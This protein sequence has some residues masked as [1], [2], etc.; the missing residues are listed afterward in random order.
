MEQAKTAIYFGPH[1]TKLHSGRVIGALVLL[2]ALSFGLGYGASSF[3]D[4]A[5]SL[6]AR[7]VQAA[8]VSMSPLGNS[9]RLYELEEQLHAARA[10]LAE[11][12]AQLA[13]RPVEAIDFQAAAQEHLA[14]AVLLHE[15]GQCRSAL[16]LY[17]F[18]LRLDPDCLEAA[19]GRGVCQLELGHAFPGYLD[20]SAA[21]ARRRS[22]RVQLFEAL[23]KRVQAFGTGDLLAKIAS[24]FGDQAS[25][26]AAYL[27][28]AV[29]QAEA[30]TALDK[31]A[32][33]SPGLTDFRRCLAI[34]PEHVGA[35]AYA[36]PPR[37]AESRPAR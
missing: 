35:L 27:R 14:Q 8:G 26:Q 20:L 28:G 1:F 10:A 3:L 32:S 17:S 12:K 31:A 16:P 19:E 37:R 9:A 25:A 18:V 30:C 23:C 2:Q 34:D 24:R 13:R 36:K 29:L 21:A 22:A 5:P 33:G 15:A 6:G 7:T 4:D 11:S